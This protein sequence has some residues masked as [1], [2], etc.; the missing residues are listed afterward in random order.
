[1]IDREYDILI[2]GSGAGGA[3]VAK[4]LSPLC[5]DGLK[6]AVLEWGPKLAPADYESSEVEMVRRLY[7]DNGGLLTQDRSITM[8]FGK[9]YG[10]S[11]AVYTGTS[12]IIPEDT[13]K[14]W[15]VPGL[16]WRDL[17]QRSRKYMEENS[18]HLLSKEEINE[19]NRL[20]FKGC[21]RLGY[22]VTQFPVNV[23]NCT[24]AGRCN[25]GCA[26]MAKQGTHVVQ[27]PLAEKNGVEVVTNCKV[28]RLG[29]RICHATVKNPLFGL[30]SIWE[31]GDYRI[32]AKLVV[33]CA[34]ALN[35][36]ALLLRSRL[37]VDFPMLGRYLTLHPAL[38]LVGQHDRPLTN[39]YGHPKSYYCG[40]FARSKGFFI[41]TCM[42]FPFM[43]AK[44]MMGF[45]ADH[46][47]MMSRMDH[48]QMILT[49]ALDAPL[50]EN[51]LTLGRKGDLQ[52]R[53]RLTREVLEALYE[54]MIASAR[55]FFAAGARRVHAPAARKFFIEASEEPL[56]RELI[57][58][59]EMKPGKVSL[60]SAH[61]MGG[62]RMGRDNKDSVTDPVGRVHGIDWLYVADA[63]LFPRCSEV[64][65]YLTV[66][67]LADRVAEN[68]R[69]RLSTEAG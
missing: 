4:E 40:H 7:F 55:I 46:S 13:V 9:A 68:I 63:S 58:K 23:K 15:Q 52:V 14:K 45:G 54:S 29:D 48:L 66:M 42:Y 36:S 8:A 47:R 5:A 20:F 49:Q 19:N 22:E 11:T 51:R 41:E 59:E 27:L 32:K 39:F 53:Y 44:S 31:E 1:M 35:T 57:L 64:N 26:N 16:E 43:T 61:L 34:G 65:P 3:V 30:P 60:A 21:T 25:I 69:K 56:L 12:L 50:H 37:P 18:V 10:G 24:G 33:V 17:E 28:E 62:C 38:V 67:A 2:I 6:I